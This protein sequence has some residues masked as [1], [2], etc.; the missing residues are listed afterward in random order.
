MKEGRIWKRG[1]E[2]LKERK[3]SR[4]W[5]LTREERGTALGRSE[6]RKRTRD[7]RVPLRPYY[8]HE[9]ASQRPERAHAPRALPAH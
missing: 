3:R 6:G 9:L 1:S 8:G 4:Q 7:R 5:E 2:G